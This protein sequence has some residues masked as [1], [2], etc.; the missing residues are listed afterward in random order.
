[1]HS[2][3]YIVQVCTKKENNHHLPR[4]LNISVI[5]VSTLTEARCYRNN[6]SLVAA[7]NVFIMSRVIYTAVHL[8]R[9]LFFILHDLNLPTVMVEN[10]LLDKGPGS[11]FEGDTIVLFMVSLYP[12]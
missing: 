1:M 2:L 3:I 7:R 10:Y 6:I 9:I 11:N 12:E 5:F 8:S 4:N